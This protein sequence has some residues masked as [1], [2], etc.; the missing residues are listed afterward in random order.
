MPNVPSCANFL[1]HSCERSDTY[2]SKETDFVFVITC[3]TCKGI[4]VWPKK[5]PENR[6]RYENFLHQQAQL[7]EQMEAE[8]RQRG[9]SISGIRPGE[10]P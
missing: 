1:E 5:N 10:R 3:R 7:R 6:A 8:S 9:Y 4:S 2:I